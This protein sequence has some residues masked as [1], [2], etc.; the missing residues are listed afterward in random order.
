M[1]LAAVGRDAEIVA[2]VCRDDDAVRRLGDAAEKANGFV[3][4]T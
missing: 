3:A 4:G 1:L 2:A